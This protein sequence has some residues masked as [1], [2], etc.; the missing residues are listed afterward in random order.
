MDVRP[1]DRAEIA[2]VVTDA[3]TAAALGSGSLPVLGT[4]R[5]LAWAEAATLE[6]LAGRLDA[7][8]GSVGTRVELA[9]TAPSPVGARVTVRAEVRAVDGRRVTFAVEAVAEDGSAL[10]TGTVERVVVDEARFLTRLP[11][12]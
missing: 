4:P 9:H 2:R 3:D 5:L 8:A 12:P 6:A 10:G 11:R 1:G 7:G